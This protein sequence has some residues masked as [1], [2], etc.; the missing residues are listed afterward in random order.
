ML[1]RAA[2]GSAAGGFLQ[3]EAAPTSGSYTPA[4]SQIFGIL[5]SMKDDFEKNLTQEQQEEMKAAAD[6]AAMKAATDSQIAAGKEK[7]DETE[8]EHADN[9]KALSDAKEELGLTRDQRS[10]DVE[11]LR[12]LKLTCMDLDKQWEERSK[13]RSAETKAVSEAISV[14]TDD[15]NMDL[16]RQT[17]GFLQVDS[18]SEE[19]AEMKMRRSR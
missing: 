4:S 7:L 8:G 16:L 17:A 10:K 13:T 5:N 3:A 12:N 11:F 19:G 15:D 14:L 9:Q 2:K 18:D 1:A 6:F